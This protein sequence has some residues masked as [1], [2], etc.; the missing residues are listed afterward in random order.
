MMKAIHV[1]TAVAA[2]VF[3]ASLAV[4]LSTFTGLDPQEAV[5]RV[6]L[7]HLAIFPPFVAAIIYARQAAGRDKDALKRVIAQAPRRLRVLAG[8]FFAYAMV[9]FA[10]FVVLPEGGTP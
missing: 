1:W 2:A 9:N 5:P 3:L 7:L 4:H 6:M 8:A 10:T